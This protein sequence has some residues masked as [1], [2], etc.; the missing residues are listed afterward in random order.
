M[1]YAETKSTDPAFNLAFEQ[2]LLENIMEGDC[3]M[4]WQNDRTVVIGRNQNAER[5]I[6]RRFTSENGIRIVRR[7]TGGGAVYHDLG[8]LN[9]S[10]ITDVHEAGAPDDTG[11]ERFN[12]PVCRALKKMGLDACTTGRNDITV[13]GK[14]VSGVAQRIY[15]DRILH[16]GCILFSSDTKVLSGALN[17][18]REKYESKGIKSVSSRIANISELLGYE[19]TMAE[20]KD[21]IKAELLA[22]SNDEKKVILF[23]PDN[24]ALTEID[25]IADERYRSW[26]WT[27][28]RSPECTFRNSRRFPGGTLEAALDV[29]NGVIAGISFFGDFMA[30]ADCTQAE[31]ALIG[32]RY[33][34]DEVSHILAQK[35]MAEKI[36]GMFGAITAENI[37]EVMFL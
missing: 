24:A 35:D 33:D 5:E 10:F 21:R 15:K 26:E 12:V 17:A 4:L 32:A 37:V 34:A 31:S 27:F 16:H 30:T 6:N 28:G 2:Y 18:D 11:I 7:M 22:E 19:M 1:I 13:D 14:K 25:R 3:V 20:F 9:Y 36:P 29:K 23:E 8:N